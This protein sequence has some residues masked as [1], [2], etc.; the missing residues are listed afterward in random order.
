[1]TFLDTITHTLQYK[2]GA[3]FEPY[4]VAALLSM[5]AVAYLVVNFVYPVAKRLQ[6][7][8]QATKI[9][10]GPKGHW[11]WGDIKAVSNNTSQFF[12]CD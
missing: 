4:F 9:A 11:F 6:R 3:F 12:V 7:F 1:M 2:R 8:R 5:V 10:G